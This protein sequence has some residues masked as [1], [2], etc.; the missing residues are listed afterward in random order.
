MRISVIGID[1]LLNFMKRIIS[2]YNGKF[3]Y[4][5]PFLGI[6]I[7]RKVKQTC[8]GK[9]IKNKSNNKKVQD[10]L[11]VVDNPF[12]IKINK[13]E[14]LSSIKITSKIKIYA[15]LLR[16]C[17]KYFFPAIYLL[18]RLRLNWFN[19]SKTAIEIFCKIFPENQNILCLPRSVFAATTSR[20]FK[21]NGIMIVGVF[22]PTRHMHAWIIEDGEN[23]YKYDDIWINYTPVSILI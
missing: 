20:N 2:Y 18:S 5:N 15:K 21:K 9:E 22:H 6:L 16:F 7:S 11:E 12:L 13:N 8:F 17:H 19:N 3:Y 23:S 14:D 4:F 10:C 1:I